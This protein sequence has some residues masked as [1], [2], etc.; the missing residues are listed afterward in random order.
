MFVRAD[1]LLGESP[2]LF[3]RHVIDFHWEDFI[4]HL[5]AFDMTSRTLVEVVMDPLDLVVSEA[6][7]CVGSFADDGTYRPCPKNVPVSRFSQCKEC[8]G[9]WIPFQECV[10]EPKCDGSRCDLHFCKKPHL[11][12]AAFYG[13]AV[14]IGMTGG[15]RLRER[16]IEQGADAIVALIDCQNRLEARQ[17]EKEVSRRLRL[18][19]AM[20][21]K[22]IAQQLVKMPK[23]EALEGRYRVIVDE[24]SRTWEV[25]GDPLELL[26]DYPMRERFAAK[27]T[28][29]ETPGTHRGA[30]V[31]VKG[32]FLFYRADGELRMLELADLPGRF[33]DLTV[34][35]S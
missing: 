32:K 4:P 9:T 8:A 7:R 24:L 22:D 25:R 21:G 35:K 6:A 33:V 18:T 26:A 2:D 11:V 34:R 29:A 27:P 28:V 14:K 31:G 1:R 20:G 19:Q 15:A 17:V 12:Y 23:P 30:V 3:S 5:V 13:D 16:A 10:F